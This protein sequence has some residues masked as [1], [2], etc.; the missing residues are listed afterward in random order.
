MPSGDV[1]LSAELADERDR[2]LVAAEVERADG[3]ALAA[4]ALDQ[5]RAAPDIAPPRSAASAGS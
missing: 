2:A 5:T 3:D 4:G 1:A